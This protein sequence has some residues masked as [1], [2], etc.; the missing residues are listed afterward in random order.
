MGHPAIA[1]AAVIAVPDPKWDERPLA[2]CVLR[3]GQTATAEELREFLRGKFAKW[4]LPDYF[5][6]VDELPHTATGKLQKLKLRE[7]FRDYR[8][9]DPG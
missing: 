1:E 9:P 5:E 4:C 3:E 6:F 2:V 8:L 7:A